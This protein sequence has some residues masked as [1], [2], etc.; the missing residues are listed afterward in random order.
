MD[1]YENTIESH[2]PIFNRMDCQRLCMSHPDCQF[3]T[4][5]VTGIWKDHCVL[6]TSDEGRNS[7]A[8][9]ISGRRFC[10]YCDVKGICR[11]SGTIFD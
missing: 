4:F 10:S 9:L 3:W 2:S 7:S 6:K 11:V 5:G 8:G 1:Y